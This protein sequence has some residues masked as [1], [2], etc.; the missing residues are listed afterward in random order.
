MFG[1]KK[2]AT[3][4]PMP[5]RVSYTKYY[6]HDG[7]LR[8]YANR[9]MVL[10][11]I[12]GG[13]ALTSLGFA[14]Y[15]RVQPPTVIKVDRNGEATVIGGTKASAGSG[16]LLRLGPASA[17]AS[18]E[19]APTDVEGRAVVR[20]FLE[21]YL[22]YTPTSVEKQLAD[23]LNV[24]TQNLRQFTL[25]KLREDDT[26]GKIKEDNI[27]SRFKVQSIEP[28]GN[29][30][31]TYVAFG[32]KELHRFQQSIERTDRI[33]GRYTIRLIQERRSERN[34]SGLLLAEYKEEQMVGE[35]NFGLQ[36]KSSLLDPQ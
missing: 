34:P 30:P 22:T 21:N 5:E 33:V 10:A 12:F 7:M 3:T 13:I 29:Q 1:N 18:A 9:S 20:R 17:A 25:S 4:Q 11:L 6:E 27:T 28:L 26:V 14:V 32:V 24:M 16:G 35:K 19:S 23:A 31:W 36:Q 15:V 8:A 2:Q